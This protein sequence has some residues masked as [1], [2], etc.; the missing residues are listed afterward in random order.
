[1][2]SQIQQIVTDGKFTV[3]SIHFL[4]QYYSWKLSPFLQ[5]GKVKIENTYTKR[6]A[7]SDNLRYNRYYDI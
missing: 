4:E 3:E 5:T 6:I 7:Y 2:A 1:M